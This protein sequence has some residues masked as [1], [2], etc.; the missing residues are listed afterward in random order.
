[1]IF[2]IFLFFVFQLSY[3]KQL[4]S[5]GEISGIGTLPLRYQWFEKNFDFEI[6]GVDCNVPQKYT[7]D[8]KRTSF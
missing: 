4:V 5:L 8:C 7:I 3:L 2:H 6:P 1:M